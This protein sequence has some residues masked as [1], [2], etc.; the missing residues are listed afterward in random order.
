MSI[1]L[2]WQGA[3]WASDFSWERRPLWVSLSRLDHHGSGKG[4][5]SSSQR[6]RIVPNRCAGCQAG[7]WL[8]QRCCWSPFEGVDWK[9]LAVISWV[10]PAPAAWRGASLAWAR[11]PWVFLKAFGKGQMRLWST[12]ID[13]LQIVVPKWCCKSILIVKGSQYKWVLLLLLPCPNS[14][15]TLIF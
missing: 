10:P 4:P 11:N 6:D 13:V 1:C 7:L 12:R 9:V 2:L 8:V 3:R 15:C 5:T 14:Y